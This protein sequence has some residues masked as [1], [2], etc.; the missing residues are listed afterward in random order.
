[1]LIARF[2]AQSDTFEPADVD[3]QIFRD[4]KMLTPLQL[5]RQYQDWILQMHDYYDQDTE[6]GED[7]PVIVVSPTNKK[8]LGISSEGRH[9]KL[10]F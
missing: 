10:L 8:A 2:C 7:E 3:V 1:M 9:E 4:N 6:C 5:E